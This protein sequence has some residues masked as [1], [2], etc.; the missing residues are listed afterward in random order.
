[1]D[2]GLPGLEAEFSTHWTRRAASVP[3]SMSTLASALEKLPVPSPDHPDRL[4]K[5]PP[6]GR[7]HV[8]ASFLW[9]RLFPQSNLWYS[10]I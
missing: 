5:G 3:P 10:V 2:L 8:T 1:V 6:W 7:L 9:L 4:S